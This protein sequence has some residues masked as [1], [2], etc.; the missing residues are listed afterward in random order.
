[1]PSYTPTCAIDFD[2][3]IHSYG[4]FGDGTVKGDPIEGAFQSI[5]ELLEV[6][7]VCIFSCRPPELIAA[8]LEKHN[9]PFA[10]QVI[11]ETEEFRKKMKWDE[12]MIV[13]ITQVKVIAKYYIDDRG[14]RFDESKPGEWR[15]TLKFIFENERDS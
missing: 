10:Y 7:H 2:G 6:M 5:V 3:V 8:W 4:E 11:E 13:G 14:I 12:D 15:D 1:M 9:A